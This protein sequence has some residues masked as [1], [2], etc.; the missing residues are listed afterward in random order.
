MK[1]NTVY[2]TL[3]AFAMIILS[4]ASASGQDAYTVVRNS[5]MKYGVSANA[6]VQTYEW[7]VYTDTDLSIEAD[8]SSECKLTPVTGEPHSIDVEWLSDGTYYLTLYATGTNGCTNKKAWKY[9]VVSTAVIAFDEIASSDCA[10]ADNS[11]ATELVAMFDSG[12]EL[13]ESQYP[14]T[15]SYRLD[16]DVADRTATVNYADKMLNVLGILEDENKETI[17]N[18]TITGATNKYGG[19]IHVA[20]GKDVHERTIF[21]KP[22]ITGIELK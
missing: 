20:P 21:K 1:I 12:T 22:T 15:V 8:A 18:I 11:F 2:K 14:V 13:A 9:T 19:I 3:M 10:D 4:L 16:G 6:E 17:N 7:K 5:K